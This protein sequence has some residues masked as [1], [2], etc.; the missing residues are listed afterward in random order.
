LKT[1]TPPDCDVVIKENVMTKF[2]K[3]TLI[4]SIMVT[5]SMLMSTAQAKFVEDK[6]PAPPPP[7]P[8]T[9]T[10]PMWIKTANPSMAGFD[11]GTNSVQY[12][13]V[14]A[15]T[16]WVYDGDNPPN[17]AGPGNSQSPATIKTLIETK[18]E[19]TN[20][21]SL[22]SEG[23][24][25]EQNSKNEDKSGSFN[26]SPSFDY[27]A[28]HYGQGELLFHWDSPFTTTTAFSFSNLPHGISNYRAYLSLGQETP[29][30]SPVPEPETYG[31]MIAG[32]G[33]LGFMARRR[34]SV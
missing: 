27:L 30:V 2:K 1:T 13:P 20:A 34:K 31:M 14:A 9:T 10:S 15:Q 5:S 24:F 26:I 32:L 8:P 18:F 29:P 12:G 19:L 3:I 7:L 22:T 25:E 23:D 28:I 6:K 17:T 4:F 11:V 21:I 16:V 33:L